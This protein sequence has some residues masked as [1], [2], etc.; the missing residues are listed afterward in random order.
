MINNH[1]D[2]TAKANIDNVRIESFKISERNRSCYFRSIKIN[3]MSRE[4][5]NIYTTMS[6]MKYICFAFYY[7]F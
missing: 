7:L 4:T 3:E 5:K 6:G 1:N 2:V